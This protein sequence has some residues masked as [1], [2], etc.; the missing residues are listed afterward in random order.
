MSQ[1]STEQNHRRRSNSPTNRAAAP[2]TVSLLG[3]QDFYLFNAGRHTRLYEKLGAHPMRSEGR[4]GTYF[5]VWAPNAEAVSVA[6]TF[7]DWSKESHPL[8]PNGSSGIWEGFFPGIG[9]GT[10]Y[11]YFIHS[12]LMGYRVEKADPFATFNEIPPKKASIVW[13]LDYTWNDSEWMKERK[14]RNTLDKPMSIYEVHLGSWRRVPEE[15]N[16]SL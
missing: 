4:D 3:D 14:S 13:N 15:G 1:E 12:R 5:A 8:H 9:Q 6:G 2:G 11:K 16:R 10:L 7:N